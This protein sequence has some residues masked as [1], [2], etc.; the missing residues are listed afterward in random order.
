MSLMLF[1]STSIGGDIAPPWV[2]QKT[3]PAWLLL[4]DVTHPRYLWVLWS[5]LCRRNVHPVSRIKLG[6]MLYKVS[7]PGTLLFSVPCSTS[8]YTGCH[9]LGK[10]DHLSC[11]FQRRLRPAI[12]IFATSIQTPAVF[13]P[14]GPSRTY[15]RRQFTRCT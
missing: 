12:A 6:T 10:G 2:R 11:F 3:E 13:I 4:L 5:L 9:G 7:V 1:A 8:T 15:H 14:T